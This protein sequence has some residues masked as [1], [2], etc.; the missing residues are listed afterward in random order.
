MSDIMTEKIKAAIEKAREEGQVYLRDI[1]FFDKED[2]RMRDI[3]TEKIKAVI[4]KAREEG[5]V[6]LRDI[7]FFDPD[8]AEFAV[9]FGIA[10]RIDSDP[11]IA[12]NQLRLYFKDEKYFSLEEGEVSSGG[13][14]EWVGYRTYFDTFLVIVKKDKHKYNIYYHICRET[15]E[16]KEDVSIPYKRVTNKGNFLI[17]NEEYPGFNPL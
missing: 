5:Q 16:E 3:M 9:N 14:L 15:E 17:M 4:E 6:Y 12:A 11:L 8:V 7:I 1:T 2:D 13:V 10:S